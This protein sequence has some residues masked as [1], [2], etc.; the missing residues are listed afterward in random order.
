MIISDISLPGLPSAHVQAPCSMSSL[1]I[2]NLH[3]AFSMQ[4]VQIDY[5]MN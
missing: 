3:R 2:T 4:P 1:E 5:I